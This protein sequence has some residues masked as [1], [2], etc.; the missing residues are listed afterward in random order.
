MN[1]QTK[2]QQNLDKISNVAFA[3]LVKKH[4]T[5]LQNP[6]FNSDSLEKTVR[7]LHKSRQRVL[8]YVI[9]MHLTFNGKPLYLSQDISSRDIVGIAR[10]TFNRALNKNLAPLGLLSSLKIKGYNMPKVY[11]VLPELLKEETLDALMD[12][13]PLSSGFVRALRIKQWATSDTKVTLLTPVKK[14]ED[15][16]INTLDYYKG[17]KLEGGE[18]LV[19]KDAIGPKRGNWFESW[20][21]RLTINPKTRI[22]FLTKN[23]FLTPISN[24]VKQIT[25]EIGL[26]KTGQVL[27]SQY[28]ESALKQALTLYKQRYHQILDPFKWIRKVAQKHSARVF[29]VVTAM[30]LVAAGLTGY[31]NTTM[32]LAPKINIVAPKAR[33]NVKRPVLVKKTANFVPARILPD[34]PEPGF[35]TKEEATSLM[36]TLFGA[37]NL[38]SMHKAI[39]KREPTITEDLFDF[40]TMRLPNGMYLNEAYYRLN[41]STIIALIGKEKYEKFLYYKR[42]GLL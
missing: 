8:D 40:R 20:M 9:L 2:S 12:V 17:V 42:Q 25:Q 1:K 39:E 15:L 32:Q 37:H 16:F 41:D 3:A 21:R 28:P 36:K 13:L 29:P 6:V 19:Y 26:T 33:P 30:L 11:K 31:R 38:F 35:P 24:Q 18:D 34:M 14:K 10:E 5:E 7:S 27:L 22:E 4:Y 23:Q